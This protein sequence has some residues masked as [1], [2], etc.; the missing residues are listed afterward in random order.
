MKQL[1]LPPYKDFFN[2]KESAID[3]YRMTLKLVLTVN[4]P[5]LVSLCPQRNDLCLPEL[6]IVKCSKDP[7][8][9]SPSW[10]PQLWMVEKSQVVFNEF[11]ITVISMIRFGFGKV[12]IILNAFV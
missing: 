5:T 8:M 2:E 7:D 12:Q 9:L 3:K 10:G 11:F 1:E 4:I 6:V